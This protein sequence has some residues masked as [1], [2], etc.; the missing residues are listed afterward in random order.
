MDIL[1]KFQQ[2]Q[3]EKF[4]RISFLAVWKCICLVGRRLKVSKVRLETKLF[5]IRF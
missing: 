1:A 4:W 5:D 2:K 3:S